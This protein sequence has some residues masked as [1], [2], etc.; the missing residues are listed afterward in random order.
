MFKKTLL[1]VLITVAI[2]SCDA[3]DELTKFDLDYT[4]NYTIQ[5]STVLDV[6]IDIITPEVTTNSE[7]EFEN[8]DTNKDLIESIKLK[9][10]TLNLRTPEDG[11]FNFINDIT[12]FIRAEGLPEVAIATA[13]DLPENG[14]RRVELETDNVELKEYIKADSYTLRTM[15]TTDGFIDE[16]HNIDIRTVFRVDAKILGI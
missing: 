7:E 2:T 9:T 5:A 6:P 1:L 15:T 13:T 14:A 12:I 16:D 10:L 8:N 4:T 11:N 3:V